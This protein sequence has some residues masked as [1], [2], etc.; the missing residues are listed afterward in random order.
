MIFQIVGAFTCHVVRVE[1]RR[2][3]RGSVIL[4]WKEH[5]TEEVRG[6]VGTGLVLNRAHRWR[7]LVFDC[8]L[9]AVYGSGAS[10]RTIR[11]G[12][13]HYFDEVHV[14]RVLRPNGRDS[15]DP[16]R[17]Q[18]S[19]FVGGGAAVDDMLDFVVRLS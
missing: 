8:L 1:R 15:E 18:C 11:L 10:Q 4:R 5:K 2:C 17:R 9:A 6:V 14:S 12:Q 3:K 19:V 13:G 16:G 7:F